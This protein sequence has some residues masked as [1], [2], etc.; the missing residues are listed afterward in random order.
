MHSDVLTDDDNVAKVLFLLLAC[1]LTALTNG[2][3]RCSLGGDVVAN[4]GESCTFTC[5]TGYEL[6][7]DRTRNCQNDGSWSG[8]D[9][10]C[11]RGE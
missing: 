8:C 4:P 7:G 6:H 9:V 11:V 1:P 10:A 3:R 2:M 5:N